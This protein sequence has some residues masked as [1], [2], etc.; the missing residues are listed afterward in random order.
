MTDT[1]YWERVDAWTEANGGPTMVK[2]VTSSGDPVE[3]T[4]LELRSFIQ[5]LI[6][7]LR[8]ADSSSSLEDSVFLEL[9]RAEALVLASILA[10]RSSA[11]NLQ[12]QD[13]AE[14]QALDNLECVIERLLTEPCAKDYAQKLAEAKKLVS[15]E[16]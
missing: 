14:G 4:E 8:E 12:L 9:S 1:E 2:V 16:T 7:C 6:E 13:V 5:K 11:S 3:L 15:P 10:K